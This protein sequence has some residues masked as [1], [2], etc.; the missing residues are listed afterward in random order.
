MIRKIYTRRYL[1]G[2]YTVEAAFIIPIIV[3]IVFAMIFML[4]YLHD[5][6]VLQANINRY[7]VQVAQGRM[8]CLDGEEWIDKM[9]ENLWMFKNK[10]GIISEGTLYIKANIKSV[11]H[12]EIFVAKVFNLPLPQ[13]EISTK[14][15]KI[16]PETLKRI[17]Q[18]G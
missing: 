4:F 9:Q 2:S 16:H 17:S 5:K 8:E 12:L 14:Y 6:V 11:S 3:G 1:S 7:V 18:G 13:L 10:S 15:M